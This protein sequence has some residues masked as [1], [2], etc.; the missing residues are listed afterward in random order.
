GRGLRGARAAAAQL[1]AVHRHEAR[2]EAV[3]AGV[4][5]VARGLVDLALA[6]ELGLDRLHGN[7]VGLHAAIA[8]ALADR[9]V[10]ED[11]LL[12]IGKGA[13][14]A[15]PALL[16]RA[17]LVVYEHRHAGVFAQLALHVVERAAVMHGDRRGEIAGRVLL[18]L[19]GDDDDLL[20]P[21]RGDLAR[22]HLGRERTVVRLAAGHGDR[23]VE[24]DLVGDGRLRRHGEADGERTRMEVGAVA[25]VLEDVLRLGERRLADPA[26]PFR[27]HVREGCGRAVHP[28]R[29]V[30]A[31]DAGERARSLGH[32]GGRVVRAAGAEVRD[33]I[34]RRNQVDARPLL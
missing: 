12:G 31:A 16:G 8:A 2:A 28:H 22:D 33:A 10:D 23:V 27:A 24:E 30:V 5:L 20:D 11:P 6:A 19:V 13:A 18:G 32:A 14:L 34:A 25:E 1:A 29:H 26:R 21:F 17:G 3:D 4:V 9:F 7:A 15:A